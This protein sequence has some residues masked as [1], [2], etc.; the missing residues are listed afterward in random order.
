MCKTRSSSRMRVEKYG[1]GRGKAML[2][3]ALCSRSASCNAA[4]SSADISSASASSMASSLR[5]IRPSSFSRMT[6]DIAIPRFHMNACRRKNGHRL[7]SGGQEQKH[8]ERVNDA[9]NWQAPA[10]ETTDTCFWTIVFLAV[11]AGLVCLLGV[12]VGRIIV[13]GQYL[14]TRAKRVIWGN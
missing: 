10:D 14:S 9:N 3:P 6:L 8:F 12:L 11:K 1:F 4:L 2:L 5:L 13:L 7:S